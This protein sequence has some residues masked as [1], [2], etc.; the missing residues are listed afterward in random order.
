MTRPRA[1]GCVH[2]ADYR[3]PAWR[4]AHVELTFDLDFDRTLVHARLQLQPDPAQPG[5]PL[6]LDGEDL[7]LLAI[8]VDGVPLARDAYTHADGHLTLPG[9]H[10]AATLET[11]VALDPSTNV[12]LEGLYRSGEL[13]LTQCEA[14]GFR[15]ITFFVDRPDV[16][17]TWR[18]TLR[19]DRARL[20]VLL[21]N[22]NPVGA[23]ALDDGR[24]EASWH[25]PHPT[26][27][28]LFAL[29]AGALDSVGTTL[30]TSEGRAVAINVWAAP[31]EAPRCRFALEAAERALRWDERRWGRA[32]DLD[33]FNIVAAQDFTMGAMENKGLNIFNARYIL[34]DAASATDADFLGIESVVGHEYFHNWSGNRVTLRDWFQLALKEGLTVFRDQEFVADL[35]SRAVKRIDDVRLLRARQF[36]EDSGA[37]A[38]AVRPERYREINNFYTLT[39]YEKGAELIRMLHTLLGEATFRAGL[40]RYFAT[41]DGGAATLED[42]LAA[43]AAASGRDLGQFARWFT[44][45]G[46][47]TLEVTSS[48]DAAAGAHTVRIEQPEPALR[49]PFRVALYAADGALRHEATLELA[50]AVT[51]WT[52]PAD[53]PLLASLNR[54]FSAPVRVHAD[55]SPDDLGRLARCDGD[56][57]NRWDAIQRLATGLLLGRFADAG[58][59]QAS[60]VAAYADLLQ[61]ADADPAFVAECLQ[62]PDF[63]TLAELAGAIDVD[64]LLAA[65]RGL[66]RALATALA[67]QLRAR[68][69]ALAATAREGRTAPAIAARSLRAVCLRWLGEADP[70]TTLAAEQFASAVEMTERLC[71]LRVLVHVDAPGRAEALAAFRDAHA[72]D[73]LVTDKWITLVASR[74]A[75]DA[76]ADIDALLASDWWLPANPN[77]VRA[78]LGTFARSNP[79]AFHRADGAGYRRVA[80]EIARLDAINP[81]VAARL[82]SAFENA[83]RLVGDRCALA[84]AAVR[85]LEGRL[86]SRDSRDLLERLLAAEPAR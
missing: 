39:V 56:P 63:D 60:L 86:V 47:P 59:A 49:M 52:V 54:G 69:A 79:A 17:P 40:D 42:F 19:G 75:P 82:L 51:T 76:L 67:P 64:A 2:L 26:P 11:T 10:A 68:H 13:L 22:G 21:S 53:A 37:L 72:T 80:D 9:V 31:G 38:H 18:T 23:R 28:Y 16:L 74:P 81:Q 50:D 43:H 62:L 35:H 73:M 3:P 66:W 4:I 1:D 61:S 77:R 34:A 15:R 57:F 48:F 71:A 46:T 78:L 12:R 44:Q 55:E 30:T 20:P 25:N 6:V 85:S 27:C 41:H 33:V 24:H 65:R 83:S 29:A 32:Y 7:E 45:V 84:F 14:E 70:R 5:E 36:A 8:A 58:D